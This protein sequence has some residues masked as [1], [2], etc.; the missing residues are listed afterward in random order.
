MR[1]SKSLVRSKLADPRLFLAPLA[2]RVGDI[3]TA[4]AT[5][6]AA[7]RSARERR[8]RDLE[9]RLDAFDPRT[10]LARRARRLQA[11]TH[12]LDAGVAASLERAR[13][14][15]NDASQKLEP[16]ARGVGSRLGQTLALARAHLDGND[17]E[18]ILQRGYAIVT[19]RGV[20]AR[21]P[22][23]IAP[24]EP[25]EARVARGTIFA[26]VEREGTDGN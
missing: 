7:S 13:A 2:Q 17:P 25:I 5:L 22:A 23:A 24:G 12:A 1:L 11:A 4:L 19:Y 15:S 14:R 20:I 8:V 6:A 16:A 10:R 3:E 18:A 26:R 21:D 9:R